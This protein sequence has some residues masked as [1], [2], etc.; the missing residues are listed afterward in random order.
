M[1][2][3]FCDTR[4]LTFTVC[5]KWLLSRFTIQV[6][7]IWRYACNVSAV[8]KG[9]FYGKTDIIMDGFSLTD[10]SMYRKSFSRVHDTSLLP[11][12]MAYLMGF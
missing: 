11:E 9:D 10:I 6:C 3:V 2:A 7:L 5:F 4:V 1:C 8:V 12:V